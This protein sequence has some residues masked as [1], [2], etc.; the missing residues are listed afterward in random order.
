MSQVPASHDYQLLLIHT[1]EL[2]SCTSRTCCSSHLLSANL[3]RIPIMYAASSYARVLIQD[4]TMQYLLL[5]GGGLALFLAVVAIRRRYTPYLRNVPAI[6]VLATVSRWEYV[7]QILTA[8]MERNLLE[9]HRRLGEY[10]GIQITRS[11][12]SIRLTS[13]QGPLVRIAHNEISIA[14]PAAIP[15]IYDT[16]QKWVKVSLTCSTKY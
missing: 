11:Q 8:R 7:R 16:E 4:S 13:C 14:D 1:G 10:H 12:S 6:S 2:G 9:A 15:I 3:S 5:C